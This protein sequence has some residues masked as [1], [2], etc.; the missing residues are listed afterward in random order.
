MSTALPDAVVC[1][2][3]TNGTLFG[4]PWPALAPQTSPEVG[5][6]DLD[7]AGGGPARDQPSP[8]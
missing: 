3:A 5:A 1:T 7:P 8:A 6:I 2:A 4:E